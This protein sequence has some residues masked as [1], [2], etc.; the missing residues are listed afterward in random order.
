MSVGGK[1][2]A[3]AA[4]C[5]ATLASCAVALGAARRVE[6]L[7]LPRGLGRPER[8]VAYGGSRLLLL[9]DLESRSEIFRVDDNG[10]LDRSFGEDGRV[11]MPFA[12][13]VVAPDGKILVAHSGPSPTDPAD[14]DAQVTRLLGDGAVDRSFGGSGTADVDLGGHY[15]GVA[16]LMLAADGAIVIGGTKQTQKSDRG[17]SNAV[18]A[19]ARLLP[20]GAVDRSFSRRGVRI[21]P[22]GWEGGVFDVARA[23]HGGIVAEGEGYVGTVVW[24]LEPSGALDRR[25]GKRGSFTL[26]G[27]GRR[28]RYGW[29]EEVSVL[30]EV[31]VLPGGK[32]LLAAT[33]SRYGG[34]GP[35]Y[36]VL[37]LRLRADGRIDRSYGRRGWAAA[38]FSGSTFAEAPVFLPDGELVVAADAQS[39][40]GKHSDVGAVAF[41]PDGKLD[42]RFGRRGRLRV[43]LDGWDMVDDAVA[44]QGGRVVILAEP[45]KWRGSRWLVRAP[46]PDRQGR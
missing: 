36:R 17:G 28:L 27:R 6:K 19:L 23:P 12:D 13:V 7:E 20:N 44:G 18:P 3:T 35:E 46:L 8:L 34:V 45:G 21:L 30:P 22:D 29:E 4:L 32:V 16:T 24:K 11:E 39:P 1:R 40:H 26:E 5:V 14:S 42:R 31:G 43:G 33:G 37:A 10:S 41:R 9:R 15:D 25:F 38:A 2:A